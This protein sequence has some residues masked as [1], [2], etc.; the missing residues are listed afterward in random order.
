MIDVNAKWHFCQWG[1]PIILAAII[2]KNHKNQTQKTATT[3]S[4]DFQNTV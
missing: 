3:N 1:I 4:A 2:A